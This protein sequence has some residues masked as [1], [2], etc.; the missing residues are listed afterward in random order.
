MDNTDLPEPGRANI[1]SIQVVIL[2]HDAFV[3]G[4]L[5]DLNSLTIRAELVGA[6]DAVH[7]MRYSV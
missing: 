2:S 4:I 5:D 6:H 3:R 1:I 7:E